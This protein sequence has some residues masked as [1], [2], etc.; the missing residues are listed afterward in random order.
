M[1]SVYSSYLYL[2]KGITTNP[3]ALSSIQD[4]DYVSA[5]AELKKSEYSMELMAKVMKMVMNSE[6]YVLNML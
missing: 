2:Y 6:K 5:I 4:T 3:Q 1:L